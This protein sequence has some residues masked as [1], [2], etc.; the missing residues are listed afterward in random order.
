MRFMSHHITLLVINSLG[1]GHTDTHRHT[2]TNTHINDLHRTS[3]KKPG[4][5]APGLKRAPKNLKK[6]LLK[7]YEVKWQPRP[8]Y[9]GS[10]ESFGYE[11]LA[12]K[13]YF[14][15]CPRFSDVD[16]IKIFDKDNQ[17]TKH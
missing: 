7:I 2:D 8:P 12:E 15:K 9:F 1:C 4:R 16:G 14:V 10:F 3:F 17:A 11:N 6:A 13:L 5:C